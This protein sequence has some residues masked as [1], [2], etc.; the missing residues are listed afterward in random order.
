MNK[1]RAQLETELQKDAAELGEASTLD[2]PPGER[3]LRIEDGAAATVVLHRMRTGRML[4]DMEDT[5]ER[6][7]VDA[8]DFQL[9]EEAN[10]PNPTS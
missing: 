8:H 4:V 5:G 9:A 1:T 2:T 10:V 3:V 7:I 6:C